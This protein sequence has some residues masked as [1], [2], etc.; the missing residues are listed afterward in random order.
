M[1]QNRN[2]PL[3]ADTAWGGN[4]EISR[5]CLVKWVDFV[6]RAL[7]IPPNLLVQGKT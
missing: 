5:L 4:W 7:L 3:K 2:L 1:K 6:L